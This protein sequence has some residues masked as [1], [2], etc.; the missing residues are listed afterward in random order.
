MIAVGA[1]M[2]AFCT[3]LAIIMTGIAVYVKRLVW[4]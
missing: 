4:H 3:V 2:A 1:A